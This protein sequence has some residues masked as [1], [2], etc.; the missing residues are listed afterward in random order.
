LTATK[1]EA[2]ACDTR[3]TAGCPH[4]GPPSG[5]LRYHVS[6]LATVPRAGAGQGDVCWSPAVEVGMW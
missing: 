6:L 4:I 2:T 1:E 3:L 5:P